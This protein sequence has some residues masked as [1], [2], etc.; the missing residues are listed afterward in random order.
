MTATCL[1]NLVA[2]KYTVLAKRSRLFVFLVIKPNGTVYEVDP[3]QNTCTCRAGELGKPCCHRMQLQTLLRSESRRLLALSAE[4]EANDPTQ[5]LMLVVEVEE[6]VAQ[7]KDVRAFLPAKFAL[8]NYAT[9]QPTPSTIPTLGTAAAYH[10]NPNRFA[11]WAQNSLNKAWI[12]LGDQFRSFEQAENLRV[13]VYAP[14]SRYAQTSVRPV[15][16]AIVA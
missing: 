8:A 13:K 16:S 14:S 3:V 15:R 11:I 6:M 10:A 4:V 5:A 2:E 7:W 1:R 9:A 12:C